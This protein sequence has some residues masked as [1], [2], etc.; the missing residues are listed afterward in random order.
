VII[1]Y[2]EID[3]ANV[4]DE[5]MQDEK[6]RPI[7]MAENKAVIFFPHLILLIF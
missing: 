2:L 5:K 1:S 7:K 3:M 4:V 6:G